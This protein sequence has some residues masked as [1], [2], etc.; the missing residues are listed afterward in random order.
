MK[1]AINSLSFPEKASKQTYIRI[2]PTFLPLSVIG[3]HIYWQQLRSSI[4][5]VIMAIVFC[6]AYCS[7]FT[8]A[9]QG[10]GIY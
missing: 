5:R 7:R 2:K 4:I 9:D 8:N 1:D 6:I 10:K 3:P